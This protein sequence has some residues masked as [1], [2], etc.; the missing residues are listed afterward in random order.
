MFSAFDTRSYRYFQLRR[1]RWGKCTETAAGL[2]AEH[3]QKGTEESVQPCQVGQQLVPAPVKLL[4]I[5]GRTAAQVGDRGTAG[6][7]LSDSISFAI[8]SREGSPIKDGAFSCH[9]DITWQGSHLSREKHVTLTWV[10]REWVSRDHVMR[11]T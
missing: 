11:P 7:E 6:R 10:F 5:N 3:A 8:M 4:D 2:Q 1:R 9:G